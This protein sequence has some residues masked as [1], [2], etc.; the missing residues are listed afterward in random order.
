MRCGV[1]SIHLANQT[2]LI[3]LLLGTE[4]AN[5][6]TA[7]TITITIAVV[8]RCGTLRIGDGRAT[9]GWLLGQTT[10]SFIRVGVFGGNIFLP[11]SLGLML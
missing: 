3:L 1:G 10:L 9:T 4:P 2:K 7:A 5:H 11:G 6:L 8:S